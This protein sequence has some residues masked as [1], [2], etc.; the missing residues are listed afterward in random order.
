M[1]IHSHAPNQQVGTSIL[2]EPDVNPDSEWPG[3]NAGDLKRGNIIE[4]VD[5]TARRKKPTDEGT[6]RRSALASSCG[7]GQT[8]PPFEQLR[9]NPRRATILHRIPANVDIVSR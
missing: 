8:F 7:A 3:R 1:L 9:N 2:T 5:P 6:R 4:A